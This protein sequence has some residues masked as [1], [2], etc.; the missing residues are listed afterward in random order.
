MT[1]YLNLGVLGLSVTKYIL[2]IGVGYICNW[3]LLR[4][5]GKYAYN[6]FRAQLSERYSQSQIPIS[7]FILGHA[8]TTFF[9]NGIFWILYFL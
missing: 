9:T 6:E 7:L 4:N 1:I 5:T 8:I 3:H 2:R